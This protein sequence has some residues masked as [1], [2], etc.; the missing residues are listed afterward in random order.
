MILHRFNYNNK[1][2]IHIPSQIV[3]ISWIFILSEGLWY[4]GGNVKTVSESLVVDAIGSV[5]ILLSAFFNDDVSATKKCFRIL[6]WFVFIV[7]NH[8]KSKQNS[9][10]ILSNHLERIRTAYI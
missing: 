3:L 4:T 7:L 8:R 2:T 5:I 9:V 1:Y 10:F 6:R